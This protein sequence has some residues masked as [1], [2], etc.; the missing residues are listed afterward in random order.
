M[1]KFLYLITLSILLVSCGSKNVIVENTTV[2][3]TINL[4]D[5]VDDKIKVSISPASITTD[6]ITF[7]IPETV[8]G[9]YSDDDYG[10]F[11]ENVQAFD[12]NNKALK[13]DKTSDNTWQ[14][15]NA[16]QL[17]KLSYLVND[18]YDIES[19]HEVFSPAG[20]NIVAGKQFVLNLHSIV[21]YFQGQVERPY[22]I[23]ISKPDGLE[24][25]TSM[26]KLNISDANTGTDV[27]TASRYFEVIDN[28]IFYNAPNKEVFTVGGVEIELSVYSPSNTTKA[29]DLR[30]N[31]ERMIKGQMNY[32]GNLETTDR[33]SILI[34]LSSVGEDDAQGFGALEH[35]TS[36]VVVLPDGM[37]Q[38]NIDAAIVDIVS[39]EFF[40]IVTPL[41]VHS[42]EIHS[43]RYNDPVMSKHLWMYEG[44]T[45]Y[46]AQH[47]QVHE[48]LTTPQEF[49]N[50]LIGKMNSAK[51]YD[52]NIPF[53]VMSENVLDKPYADEYVHV[54][55]RGALIGMC[56]DIIMRE[57]S[58]GERGILSLMKEL[59]AKY[60]KTKP[61]ED[62]TIIAEITAMTYPEVGQF[63][64]DHVQ[65][66]VPIDYAAYFKKVG[67]E[68]RSQLAPSGYFLNGN[69]PFISARQAEDEVFILPGI[70]MHSFFKEMGIQ[71]GDVIV[72]I[73]DKKYGVANVYDLI[74]DPNSWKEGEDITF[75]VKR[76]GQELTLKGK[77]S[78]PMISTPS[79][80]E[81][82]Y[83]QEGPELRLRNSWLK[84]S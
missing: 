63:F 20:T 42:K 56:L 18:T 1:K 71:G 6:E 80:I 19:T 82:Q 84:G 31:V 51:S 61:F 10:K 24:A 53:T 40:H 59:S 69:Q 29:S 44:V 73:N 9:T 5:V 22:T 48:E 14:I 58:N 16:K 83:L 50:T 11:I 67:I 70:E 12:S 28:P 30:P 64:K 43:F 37:P 77:V 4:V 34:Y 62:D 32:L 38:E 36:T 2:K 81:T 33:Y 74:S 65:G 72:S 55:D 66:S 46:F 17:A 21:G 3:A 35:H 52:E 54:Y 23:T 78:Q 76:D 15:S 26:E 41:N 13:V 27:F 47:F 68:L 8:P 79:L 75:V 25:S 39:H 60:G 57:Q 45:E 49:Y 7:F